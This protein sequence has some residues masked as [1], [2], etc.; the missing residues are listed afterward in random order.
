MFYDHDLEGDSFFVG[1]SDLGA[2][3]D[4]DE[5][6]GFGAA[7]AGSFFFPA[8]GFLSSLDFSFCE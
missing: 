8:S 5:L 7:A 6:S 3:S 1:L 4:F 2:L